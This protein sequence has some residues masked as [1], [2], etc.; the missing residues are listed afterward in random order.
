MTHIVAQFFKK[1]LPQKL[2]QCL[3]KSAIGGKNQ[4]LWAREAIP[5]SLDKT[6]EASDLRVVRQNDIFNVGVLEPLCCALL[7]T[8]RA[9]IPQKAAKLIK[10]NLEQKV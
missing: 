7:N 10:F 8:E 9:Q 5:G 1:N 2:E 3:Q 6:E 4:N